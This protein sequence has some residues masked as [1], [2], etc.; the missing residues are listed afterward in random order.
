MEV[1]ERTRRP[2]E[3]QNPGSGATDFGCFKPLTSLA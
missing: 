1:L 2:M 3:R